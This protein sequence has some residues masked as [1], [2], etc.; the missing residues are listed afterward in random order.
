MLQLIKLFLQLFGLVRAVDPSMKMTKGVISVLGS[1]AMGGLPGMLET[2]KKGGLGSQVDSWV[3]TGK[4]Q[5]VSGDQLE[6]ALG[7]DKLTELARQFGM[8]VDQFKNQLADSLPQ[9]VD[10][11]TP[12]GQIPDASELDQMMARLGRG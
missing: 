9:A 3:S 12:Q 6:G 8:P 10:Q 2:L 4:N 5:A 1:K 7:K 11:L